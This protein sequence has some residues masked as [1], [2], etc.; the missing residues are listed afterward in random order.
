MVDV[1]L[2]SK[3]IVPPWHDSSKNLV[4]DLATHMV[5]HTP[6][7]MSQAGVRLDMPRARIEPVY[8]ETAK[9]FSPALRD[10][11]R[12]LARLLQS[13]RGEFWHFFFAPNP[14]TSTVARV[15]SSLRR[16]RTIQTVCSAPH[17]SV[18]ARGVLFA[19]RIIVLSEHTQRRFLADGIAASRMRLIRPA[20]PNLTPIEQARIPA[21]RRRLGLAVHRPLLL[22]AGDLEFGRG[23]ELALSSFIDLPSTLDACL[24]MACRAKT[25]GARARAKQ[26]EEQATRARV[27]DRVV[28]FGETPF[29]H[30]LL[31]VADVVTLPADTLYAKMDVPLVLVEAM[32]LGR[33]VLVGRDTPAAELASAGGAVAV[34]TQRDAVSAATRLLLEDS[35]RRGELGA[36]AH[37]IAKRDYDARRMTEAYEAVYDE[38]V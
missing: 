9:G 23:A 8:G 22:Y 29:I 2:V 24:V 3:P 4:R 7:V 17:P 12:V 37:Q 35:T 18:A 27:A 1:L 16:A 31:A 26:L 19:D 13:H 25:R 28:W 38:L 15:A 33:A 6:I 5:R 32:A 21:A 11:A 20:V 14:K 36:A 10:N 30:D 34:D